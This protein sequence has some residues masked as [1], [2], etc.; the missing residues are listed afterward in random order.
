MLAAVRRHW[1]AEVDAVE[2]LPVGF[3][4]HHWRASARS[5]PRLFVTLDAVGARH[6]AASLEGAYAAAAALELDFV[7]APLPSRTGTYTVP[8]ADGRLSCT[9]WT[10]G[11]V[12]GSGPVTGDGLARANLDALARLHAARP[13]AAIPRWRP[14][15]GP[16]LAET[17]AG[18]LGRAWASGPYGEA[19]RAAIAERIGAIA[20]WTTRYH[21][22]V[23]R[24]RTLPWVPTHGEPHTR[25]QIVTPGGVR[26]VDWESF[27]LAPRERDLGPLI[28]A[29]HAADVRPD[30][31]MVELYDLEWRLD[32][33]AQY[34]TWFA[35]PH[36]GDRDDRI[37][38]D[39]LRRELGRPEWRRP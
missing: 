19:A 28:E 10:A 31:A 13:P 35:G 26:L 11:T 22:L 12:A 18:A 33:I 3:G 17:L 1:P 32:E 15:V 39:G 36:T 14:R 23:D 21:G 16:E 20:A 25:N 34:A 5:A 9:P 7:V 6:S 24:A 27:A 30:W 2:H 37:A 29:G 4:A 38:L 8:L